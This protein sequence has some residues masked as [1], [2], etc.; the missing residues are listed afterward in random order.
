MAIKLQ[1][2]TE[3]SDTIT[4]EYW[5]IGVANIHPISQA[6][7]VMLFGYVNKAAR[8]GGKQPIGAPIEISVPWEAFTNPNNPSIKAIYD[9]LKTQPDWAAGE[10]V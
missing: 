2:P 4:R 10:D 5:R 8:D 7:Y 3:F 1:K 6:C 9:W